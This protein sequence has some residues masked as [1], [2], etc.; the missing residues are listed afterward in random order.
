MSVGVLGAVACG[1]TKRM[2]V[3]FQ[4]SGDNINI[5]LR[6]VVLGSVDW[7]HLAYG[8]CRWRALVNTEMNLRV[9]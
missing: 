5:D 2:A 3:L 1:Q 9:P 4:R 8:R 6:E 7:L